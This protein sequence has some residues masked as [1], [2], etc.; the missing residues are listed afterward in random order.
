MTESD[1]SVLGGLE[2]AGSA[3]VNTAEDLG[4]AGVDLGS[5]MYH[6]GAGAFDVIANDRPGAE[7][8]MDQMQADDQ[9]WSAEIDQ[10]E[11]DLGI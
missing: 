3:F 9:L 6:A 5:S 1:D 11:K 10:A 8:H 7:Q 4:S 2:T